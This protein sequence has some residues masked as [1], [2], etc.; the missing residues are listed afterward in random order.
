MPDD[1]RQVLEQRSKAKSERKMAK[2]T[3]KKGRKKRS[4]RRAA[5]RGTGIAPKENAI[6][7]DVQ[8]CS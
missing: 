8:D 5:P 2:K 4:L 7:V 1:G 6:P 3:R